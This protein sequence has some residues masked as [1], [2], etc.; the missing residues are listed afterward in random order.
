MSIFEIETARA[1][2][3]VAQVNWKKREREKKAS[4]LQFLK[5]YMQVNLSFPF[6][7]DLRLLV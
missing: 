3:V 2:C 6:S 1:V 7:L 5:M 4:L